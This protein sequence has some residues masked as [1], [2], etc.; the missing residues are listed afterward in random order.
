MRF[1]FKNKYTDQFV[2]VILFLLILITANPLILSKTIKSKNGKKYYTKISD[3]KFDD[4]YEFV[5][6]RGEK[7]P[8]YKNTDEAVFINT[9]ANKTF[10]EIIEEEIDYCFVRIPDIDY[11]YYE[12]WINKSFIRKSRKTK[13]AIRYYGKQLVLIEDLIE[14]DNAWVYSDSAKVYTFPKNSSTVKYTLDFG[15][16]VF[17]QKE[18]ED[19][20]NIKIYSDENQIYQSGWIEKE[21][22]TRDEKVLSGELLD[23]SEKTSDESITNSAEETKT[24][25]MRKKKLQEL[26]DKQDTRALE[27]LAKSSNNNELQ[28]YLTQLIED[29]RKASH[30][31][32][33]ISDLESE[34]LDLK[35]ET[36]PS[37]KE[38]IFR[39]AQLLEIKNDLN[40]IIDKKD[41]YAKS[42]IERKKLGDLREEEI[43]NLAS[44]LTREKEAR[45]FLAYKIETNRSILDEDEKKLDLLIG[46]KINLNDSISEISKKI[47]S[48]LYSKNEISDLILL[49]K[50]FLA[51]LK[52]KK[53]EISSLNLFID[54]NKTY[55]NKLIKDLKQKGDDLYSF[56]KKLKSINEQYFASVKQKKEKGIKKLKLELEKNISKKVSYDKEIENLTK[57]LSNLESKYKVLNNNFLEKTNQ[58]TILESNVL[59]LKK[60]KIDYEEEQTKILADKEKFQKIKAYLSNLESLNKSLSNTSKSINLLTTNLHS[61]QNKLEVQN[62]LKKIKELQHSDEILNLK[63]VKKKGSEYLISVQKIKEKNQ[64]VVLSFEKELSTLNVSSAKLNSSI[65]EQDL[66]LIQVMKLRDELLKQLSEKKKSQRNHNKSITKINNDKIVSNQNIKISLLQLENELEK[67]KRDFNRKNTF[68]SKLALDL[69][70]SKTIFTNDS[71]SLATKIMEL[72]ELKSNI[73][74]LKDK[75]LDLVAFEKKSKERILNFENEIDSIKQKGKQVNSD[76]KN[77]KTLIK[78]LQELVRKYNNT[79]IDNKSEIVLLTMQKKFLL[80]KK[81]N[82]VLNKGKQSDDIDKKNIR[83]E[84]RLNKKNKKPIFKKSKKRVAVNKQKLLNEEL[85]KAKSNQHNRSNYNVNLLIKEKNNSLRNMYKKGKQKDSELKGNTTLKF[86]LM[87]DGNTQNVRVVKSNWSNKKV[88]RYV[89]IL[90]EKKVR[91]WKF[92]ADN[93]KN[94]SK[95]KPK[96]V[97]KVYHF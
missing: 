63:K 19:F 93:N 34:I 31:S 18:A 21:N 45:N 83:S 7:V 65:S 94:K 33:Q 86:T 57:L 5:R 53:K 30:I 76:I 56:E 96:K 13:E 25:E 77:S 69:E 82:A 78:T 75:S 88:G 91:K 26:K 6:I 29:K 97:V 2:Y 12:G 66:R 22:V 95:I 59:S 36:N 38:I 50:V 52:S 42:E 70:D 27:I 58:T 85:K 80:K 28:Y 4:Y 35:K 11:G 84:K 79:H 20:F 14:N 87:P 61:L 89:D 41:A 49:K 55:S 81:K 46:E 39:N 54:K 17:I 60:R 67:S 47:S 3:L 9:V 15:N 44:S 40:I 72:D 51:D 23:T 48:F 73:K 92:P 24:L 32:I 68:Y 16:E 62:N 43:S 71:I 1:R 8:A 37:E 90:I 74:N 10:V 64:K